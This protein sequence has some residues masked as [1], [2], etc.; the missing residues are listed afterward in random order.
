M[1]RRVSANPTILRFRMIALL[2]SPLATHIQILFLF[3]DAGLV[4]VNPMPVRCRG[5]LHC[6]R[7][8]ILNLTM[9]LH[10]VL[11]AVLDTFYLRE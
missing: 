2:C 1:W 6:A 8:L 7:A 3:A 11:Y 9:A 10:A 5:V 4:S